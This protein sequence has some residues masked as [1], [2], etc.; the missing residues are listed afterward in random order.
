MSEDRSSDPGD[1]SWIEKIADTFSSEPKTQDELL[2]VLHGARENELIDGSALGII[3]GAMHMEETQVREIMVPRPQMT[4]IRAAD[5][6][7]DIVNTAIKHGHSR[8]P[9]IGE[10][11]DE[12]LGILLTK[13]LLP[14]LL[15]QDHSNFDL[16]SILRDATRVPETKRINTLLREF[17]E[18]RYHM[19]VVID[20]YGGVAG[21]ITIE[22][23]LEEIVGEIEDEYDVDSDA[24]IR[25]IAD[26]DYVIKAL[27]PVDEFNEYF[28][29][30][31]SDEEFETIGGLVLQQFGRLPK[32][33]E[34]AMLAH[35]EFRV[36]NA[37]SRQV[38]LLRMRETEAL[39]EV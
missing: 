18:N 37:D 31:L 34:V 13:D 20:E 33:N 10:T 8:Y 29:V 1:K 19:A 11:P 15:Q 36:I 23:V 32:R 16:I 17:R 25:K 27:T 24:Y 30:E 9:V 38:H 2:E 3:E 21:L 6:F 14:Q 26:N 5:S 35:F 39:V 7:D 4:Y 12:I 28:S 22:D